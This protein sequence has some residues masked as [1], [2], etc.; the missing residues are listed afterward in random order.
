MKIL[1]D[2]KRKETWNADKKHS[3]KCFLLT[4]ESEK[5][6]KNQRNL[7]HPQQP[8]ITEG[9]IKRSNNRWRLQN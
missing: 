5:I 6:E 2:A 9:A 1:A 4:Q 7:R 8:N 3:Y